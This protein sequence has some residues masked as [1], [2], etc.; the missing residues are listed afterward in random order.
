MRRSVPLIAALACLLAFGSS[1][2]AGAEL[3]PNFQEEVAFSGLV[4]PTVVRFSPDGRVFVAEKSGLIKVFAG[5]GDAT[6]SVYADL[7]TQV[8]N[9]WDRGL[10][11]MA[12]DPQFPAD[13]FI[14]VLYT[15]DAAI[16]GTAPRWGTPGVTADPCPNPPGGNSDG[17]IAS[18]RLSRLNAAG[19]E[20]VLVEDWCQQYPSH[21]Q[22][23]I[24]FGPDGA[25]YA[26]SGDGAAFGFADYGQDGSPVNP[27]GDPP[28]GVGAT[29]TPP[30]AEGGSLRAQDLRTA[31]DPVSLD[32]T[33]IRVNPDTG[34][35]VPGNPLFSSSD[36]NARRIVA[37]GL[38]NPFRTAFRPGTSEL[39]VADVGLGRWEEIN[40]ITDLLGTVENGGWPC[41][42]G[43]NLAKPPLFEQLDLNICL[44]LYAA[45]ASAVHEPHFAYA[46][47]AK[48]VTN[49]TCPSGSSA[50]SGLAFYQGGPYPAAYDGALFFSDHSRDCIW[51]M[52]T[53]PSGLPDP[54]KILTFVGP[55]SNPVALEIG[56]GGDL[57]YVDFDGGAIRRIR[58]FAGNQPPIA[59]A[60]ATPTN[61]PAPLQVS[62]DGRDSSDPESGALTY[63]WDLDGDGQFDDSTSATPSRTYTSAGTVNV[64]LRVTDPGALTDTDTV[65]ISVGNTAPNATIV[66]PTAATTW[67]VGQSVSFSGTATDPQDG[68]LPA[69]AY[70]W[71]LVM[72]HCPSNC[73]THPI[74]SFPGVASGS[75]DAPDHEYPSHLELR[76]TVTDSGGLQDTASVELQPRTVDVTLAANV[77]GIQLTLDDGSGPAPYVRTVIEGSAHTISAPATKTLGGVRY[78][79]RS[80]SDG[81]ARVHNITAASSTSLTATYA[82]APVGADVELTTRAYRKATRLTFVLRLKNLGPAAAREVHLTDTLPKRVWWGWADVEGG[83]CRHTTGSRT[84]TCSFGRLD[85]GE[86]AV[87]RLRTWL[88][89]TAQKVVNVGEATSTTQDPHPANNRSRFSFQVD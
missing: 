13:P 68:T 46:H 47:T 87:A 65:V 88:M 2:A 62:F 89:P 66:A 22:G 24:Q 51:A 4:Q 16:G 80:W 15:H 84:V 38:R 19:Q 41:Y 45:G 18:G 28:G 34:A 75:F 53:G 69:S 9:Y 31:G 86:L 40:R 56:P 14:Y 32:G 72:Q 48:V 55:A 52:Q 11:G 61:G 50:I 81:G 39:W 49:E 33:L 21:S 36:A 85:K 17:C 6:P 57:F 71:E 8:Y 23:Q 54:T 20:T 27:C 1:A 76:L 35:G 58:Y 42:E 63:A 37:H 59:V 3:P 79:F 5:L 10:L 70:T 26:T 60:E 29:L 74:E 67:E 64:R 82:A 78:A 25:L 7:R 77:P 12:L 73:H 30:T 44:N 43:P 83:S